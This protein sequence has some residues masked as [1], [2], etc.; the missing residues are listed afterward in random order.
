MYKNNKTS[1]CE[2]LL[3]S[4]ACLRK[5]IKQMNVLKLK[6][7]EKNEDLERDVEQKMLLIENLTR[8]FKVRIYNFIFF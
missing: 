7:Q 6:S 1:E 3:D 4:E 2:K 5:E 8:D